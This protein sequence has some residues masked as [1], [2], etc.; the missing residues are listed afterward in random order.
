MTP[1]EL[2]EHV[3]ILETHMAL[4]KDKML[5]ARTIE[6][7][8]NEKFNAEWSLK[9]VVADVKL[10]F[11]KIPDPYLRGRATDIEHVADRILRNLVGAEGVDIARIDKRVILV[12][13]DLF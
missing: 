9:K 7:I 6:T 2:R 10:M 3:D 13:A 5:Y 8:R 11:Q 1:E 12:A 4:Y